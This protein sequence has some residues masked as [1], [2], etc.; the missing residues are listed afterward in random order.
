M[1]LPKHSQ[2]FNAGVTSTALRG[3]QNL[4]ITGE[5]VARGTEMVLVIDKTRAKE[6]RFR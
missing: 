2:V 1:N 3:G 4:N 5:F 6:N